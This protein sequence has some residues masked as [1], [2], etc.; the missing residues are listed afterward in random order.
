MNER[1]MNGRINI[2]S[3]DISDSIMQKWK[4][5]LTVGFI[6][7]CGEWQYGNV[8]SCLN[9]E[10]IDPMLLLIS[11]CAYTFHIMK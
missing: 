11:L 9:T 5:E 3:N 2:V 1:I 8:F 10:L 7:D 4:N 6:E